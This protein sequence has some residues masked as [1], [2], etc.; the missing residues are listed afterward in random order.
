MDA[1]RTGSP[2]NLL[3]LPVEI[4][5]RILKYLLSTN[6][7]ENLIT[8]YR[9]TMSNFGE[10]LDD[11]QVDRGRDETMLDSPTAFFDAHYVITRK[12]SVFS[13]VLWTCK[14]LLREGT[15]LLVD[16]N[17]Y[18][19]LRYPKV[20]TDVGRKIEAYIE[21]SGILTFWKDPGIFRLPESQST[22]GRPVVRIDYDV[23]EDKSIPYHT[24]IVPYVG[25]GSLCQA[26]LAYNWD[27]AERYE[28][29][30][31]EN[32]GIF[33]ATRVSLHFCISRI[34]DWKKLGFESVVKHLDA[35][36]F[37]WVGLNVT[38]I[39]FDAL[40][41]NS[42]LER[43]IQDWIVRQPASFLGPEGFVDEDKCVD[44]WVKRFRRAEQQFL[45]NDF[46]AARVSFVEVN[47]FLAIN[48][49]AYG[50]DLLDMVEQGYLISWTHFYLGI[51]LLEHA[52]NKVKLDDDHHYYSSHA[53]S[54]T[55]Y[56]PVLETLDAF[57]I[58]P[59]H[60]ARLY[61]AKA[62]AASA[63][64]FELRRQSRFSNALEDCLMRL[65]NA[66]FEF[67]SEELLQLDLP[68]DVWTTRLLFAEAREEISK[69]ILENFGPVMPVR[70][71]LERDDQEEEDDE[72]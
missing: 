10:D 37:D 54:A 51:C 44:R 16:D 40:S 68:H 17:A 60:E 46:E 35:H 26:L 36:I 43:E 52:E 58:T 65:R 34:P 45:S 4:R 5:K 30:Y 14:Q 55:F 61:F 57:V 20:P 28:E 31:A 63:L 50:W 48:Y 56:L 33:Y 25:L 2:P 18:I 24:I 69:T 64:P 1:A 49:L 70:L 66:N 23:S 62:V 27:Y 67:D 9:H 72:G 6:W 38:S 41:T 7:Q 53:K 47:I 29:L 12:Y 71:G 15:S 11:E 59:N 13:N 21:Q 3:D 22:F 42:D 32:N 19:A 39:S 8:G